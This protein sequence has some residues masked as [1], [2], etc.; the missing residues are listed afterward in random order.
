[1]YHHGGILQ[2]GLK[3][4]ASYLENKEI[5]LDYHTGLVCSAVP[6]RAEEEGGKVN[7]RDYSLMED[8]GKGQ[9]SSRNLL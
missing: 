5:I 1:M 4:L 3:L 2:V 8:G 6:C 9:L 7:Q